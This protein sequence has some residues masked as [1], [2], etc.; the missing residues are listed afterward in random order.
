[1]TIR[2][3]HISAFLDQQAPP[4]TKLDFDN[5][6]L[7]LGSSAQQVSSILCCLDVTP[8]VIEEARRQNAELIVAHHPLIFKKLSRI[9][10]STE[11]GK[12]IADLLRNEIALFAAHTNYDIANDGVSFVM[13]E[14]LG[15]TNAEFLQPMQEQDC[16]IEITTGP[17]SANDIQKIL[18][19][20]GD[21][22]AYSSSAAGEAHFKVVT[23]KYFLKDLEQSLHQIDSTTK[24]WSYQ[25][26]QDEASHGLGVIA[27]FDSPM[28]TGAFLNLLKE[29]F[30][31][32]HIAYSGAPE[33]IERVA[34]CGGAGAP[35]ISNALGR[36]DAYVTA[37][38]K[39]HEFFTGR[40]DFLLADIG[41]YESEIPAVFELADRIRQRFPELSVHTTS[42]N[43]NP[44][45][46]H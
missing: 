30:A 10:T 29:T 7:L 20:F 1:M 44:I 25:V 5:I 26:K 36:A 23:Q 43:T 34:L 2:V 28:E 27:E 38:L 32:E 17:K 42:V 11:E 37:D 18:D 39:Y 14:K 4:T 21:S 40:E 6:G 12:M 3:E 33:K 19:Q 45:K 16:I 9:D 15:L 41:H 22:I 35:L 31:C 8:G 24:S 13:A 46:H